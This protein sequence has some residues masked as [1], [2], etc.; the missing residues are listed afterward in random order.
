MADEIAQLTDGHRRDET[1]S[2]QAVL[3]QFSQP[4]RVTHVGLAS[5]NVLD[6]CGIDQQRRELGFEDVEDR[7]PILAGRFHCD[8]RHLTLTQPIGEC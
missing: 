8:V 6:M 1:R 2:Q 3:Q 7:T 4:L 5:R